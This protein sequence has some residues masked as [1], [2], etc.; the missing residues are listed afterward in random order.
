M[1]LAT[2]VSPDP[3]RPTHTNGKGRRVSPAAIAPARA[4][5]V[6]S[7]NIVGYEKLALTADDYKMGGIQF[8]GV[9]GGA[10]TLNDLFSSTDIPYGTE[11]MFL[12]ESG[13]YDHFKYI[14][15]AYDGKDFVPGWA[16]GDEYLVTDPVVNGSGFW[17]QAPEATTL[18]QAGQVSD[19]ATESI[20]IPAND[21]TMVCNPFPEG[22]NP[23]EVTWSSDL[24]YGTEIMTSSGDGYAHF[25]YIEEAYDGTDFVPGWA[26]GD[27]YLVTTP[28]AGNGEG[29]WVLAPSEVTLSVKSPIKE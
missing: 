2:R 29:F 6:V 21:Y 5:D 23:N 25:K 27:E 14:E 11:I 15:E 18:T 12:N 13:S 20:T 4:A 22:F 26:D 9:G 1:R 8:V 10:V 16:D 19:E 28:I 3:S 17:V 24:A 7:S